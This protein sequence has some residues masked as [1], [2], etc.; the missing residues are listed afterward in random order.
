ML[1][2]SGLRFRSSR[3]RPLRQYRSLSSALHFYQN[4]QLEQYA[5]KDAQR[6]TLRQL[7]FFGRSMNE[8]R[9]I[10]SANYVRNELPVRIAHRL[11]DMQTLPYVV[12]NQEGIAD[13]YEAYCTAFDKFRRYPPVSNMAEN[14]EFCKFLR[15]ILDDHRRA[16][17]NLSLGMSLSSPYLPPDRLDPFMRRMLVSRISRRVLVEHHIALSKVVSAKQRGEPVPENRVGI[18]N[19]SLHVKDSI[20]R[21]AMYLRKRPF[22][23]DQ[24][25][26]MG[27]ACDAGWSEV[28][29]DGHLDTKFSY[30]QAHLDYIVFELLKNSF[31]ATRLKHRDSQHLPPIRAT[32]VAGE[33][34]VAIRISDQGGGL[35]TSEIRSPSDLFSF[36]HLRNPTRLD[37]SRIEALR[38]V[39][40]SGRG[41]TATVDEQVQAWENDARKIDQDNPEHRAGVSPHPR[42]GIGLPMSN[43]FA[44]YFGGSLELV[45]L[46]GYGTDVYLR[47]P[48]LGTNLEGIEL[49]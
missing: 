33:N 40:S 36:S 32:I 8:D 34:D 25:C 23:V 24:D 29:V 31:R 10:K 7:I 2:R 45:S 3:A 22:N 9:L 11:R 30:I 18:I 16:I 46:D 43:I 13:V 28:I 37:P 14:E 48:K 1:V 20:E 27:A 26:R 39:S 6:L 12:M 15:A 49:W 42:T 19:L 21:C 41:M 5:S 44:T 38:A 35:L 47:L 4:R 17:P